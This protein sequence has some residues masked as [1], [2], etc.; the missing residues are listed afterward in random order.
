MLAEVIG[1]ERP[2]AADLA[3]G[4]VRR[5]L[6]EVLPDGRFDMLTPIRRHGAFLTAST[7]DAAAD[8]RGPGPLG[9]PG[10]PRRTSTT[11]AADAPWLADLPVMKAA[12]TAAVRRTRQTRDTGYGLANR[13]FSSLYTSMRAREAVEILEAVLVSGD[14]PADDRRPGGPARR[15]RGLRGPRHLRGPVAARARRRA[16]APSAPDPDEQLARNASIRAEMHLDA[17]ALVQ[18]E[19]EA[20]RAHR[21]RRR[22][23]RDRAAG[24]PHADRRAGLPRATSRAAQQ[25]AQR[26]LSDTSATRRALDLL[27]PRTLLARIALEQGRSVEGASAAR[28]ACATRTG[29]PRTASRCSPRPCCASSTRH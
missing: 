6:L 2:E 15:H 28:A 4:L 18:A 9:R 27:S 21:P 7:D 13:I 25:S 1:V 12:I 19:A 5:S 14:G 17:G 11:G 10:G 24:H 23:A 26:I 29:S 8:P 22:R 16:R 20:R 3:A